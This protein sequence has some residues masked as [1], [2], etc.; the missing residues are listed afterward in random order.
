MWAEMVSRHA[1]PHENGTCQEVCNTTV[2]GARCRC[3][4]HSSG[5]TMI[6]S[7]AEKQGLPDLGEMGAGIK[8]QV[9]AGT[10]QEA[11]HRIRAAVLLHR[12][13]LQRNASVLR[14]L[15]KLQTNEHHI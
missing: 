10:L 9:Q 15:A 1:Q 8:A 11:S 5:T 6:G 4:M 2:A 7:S 12:A 13:H 14:D 3:C